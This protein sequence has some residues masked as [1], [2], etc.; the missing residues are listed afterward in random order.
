M[1]EARKIPIAGSDI[2]LDD[3][4]TIVE[5]IVQRH[6]NFPD[7]DIRVTI[8]LVL[9]NIGDRFATIECTNGEWSGLKSDIAPGEGVPQCPN[10]HSLYQGVGLKLG[11]LP[12]NT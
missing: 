8:G 6:E 11:W 7:E 3:V 10:G 4:K 12:S 9:C 2:T 5:S 1:P